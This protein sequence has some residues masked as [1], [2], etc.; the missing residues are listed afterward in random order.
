MRKQV[1]DFGVTELKAVIL[2]VLFILPSQCP[3]EHKTRAT[4]ELFNSADLVAVW[5]YLEFEGFA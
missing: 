3:I 4:T 1:S 5:H 2:L